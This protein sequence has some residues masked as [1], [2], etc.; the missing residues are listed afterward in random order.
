MMDDFVLKV[1]LL[2]DFS[3]SPGRPHMVIKI[4]CKNIKPEIDYLVDFTSHGLSTV[5]ISDFI[6]PTQKLSDEASLHICPQLKCTRKRTWLM[7]SPPLGHRC[8]SNQVH[9]FSMT[10]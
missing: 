9:P 8:Y 6:L 2:V 3:G 4:I 10:T 7:S 1:H 5:P